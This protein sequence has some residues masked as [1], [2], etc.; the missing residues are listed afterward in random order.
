MSL[1]PAQDEIEVQ[2]KKEKVEKCGKNMGPHNYIPIEWTT[3]ESTK[4][5]TRL[6]CLTCFENISMSFLL[7]RY[8]EIKA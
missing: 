8:P 3:T 1:T 4:R 7:S 6:I 5:V 2:R